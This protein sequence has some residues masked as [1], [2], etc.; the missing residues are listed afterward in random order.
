MKRKKEKLK[1]T[2]EV[3]LK[4]GQKFSYIITAVTEEE[5]ASKAR[6]HMYAIFQTGYRHA[7]K[8]EFTWYGK[9]WIDKIKVKG[10]DHFSCYPDV[11]SG[12]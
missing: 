2:M 10:I 11:A 8:K 4:S 7:C 3:Y 5:L 12:P 9:H 1:A 6:E